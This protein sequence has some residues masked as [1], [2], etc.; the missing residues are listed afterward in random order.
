[1][2]EDNEPSLSNQKDS[3]ADVLDEK[4]KARIEK[5]IERTMEEILAK[6][7]SLLE[8]KEPLEH[9]YGKVSE[10]GDDP[11]AYNEKVWQHFVERKDKVD[12]M[13]I[14]TVSPQTKP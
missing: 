2:P 13:E 12:N 10:P 1:M 8:G 3:E 5:S 11:C 14:P 9:C 7:R 6:K 4:T